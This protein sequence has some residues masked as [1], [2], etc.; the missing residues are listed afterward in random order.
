MV[1]IKATFLAAAA[2]TFLA[3]SAL[4]ASTFLGSCKHKI[5]MDF[6]GCTD[7]S[8]KTYLPKFADYDLDYSVVAQN[9]QELC[10]TPSNTHG[11][12]FQS[13]SRANDYGSNVFGVE[14]WF[15]GGSTK[16]K[17]YNVDANGGYLDHSRK[18]PS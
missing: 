6:S 1:I 5:I 15:Q 13:Q 17:F 8:L 4:G 3:T 10:I 9:T 12:F 18:C 16:A 7:K 2:S 11:I 14:I